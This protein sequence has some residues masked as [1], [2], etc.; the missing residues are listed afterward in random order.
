MLVW[1][2]AGQGTIADDF[3]P[4]PFTLA[5]YNTIQTVGLATMLH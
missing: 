2:Q 4:E 3:A 1:H 5:E